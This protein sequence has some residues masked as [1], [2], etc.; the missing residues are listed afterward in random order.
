MKERTCWPQLLPG[1]FKPVKR[2][3]IVGS[4]DIQHIVKAKKLCKGMAEN[5]K[6]EEGNIG[7][8]AEQKMGPSI[9]S[10]RHAYKLLTGKLY[11]PL[12]VGREKSSGTKEPSSLPLLTLVPRG[13]NLPDGKIQNI[14]AV[15]P[16]IK[17]AYRSQSSGRAEIE[18]R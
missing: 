12:L 16:A 1:Q 10:S 11:K 17:R 6:Q 18:K 14:H 9:K 7:K 4:L 2:S 5:V 15:N 3:K 8:V 13:Q